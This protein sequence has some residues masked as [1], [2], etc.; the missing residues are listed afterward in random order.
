MRQLLREQRQHDQKNRAGER[1]HPDQDME[2]KADDEINWHPG[3]VEQG[4]RAETG[5]K[6]LHIVE[7]PQR[8]DSLDAVSSPQWQPHNG[9]VNALA[10][11]LV[12]R[13]ADPHQKAPADEIDDA[14]KHEQDTR[15]DRQADQRRDAA[16][17][18][19][20]V[21]D[22]QHVKRAGQH[23]NIDQAAEE[24][25]ADHRAAAGPQRRRKF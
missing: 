20:P 24:G 14:Q 5:E 4:C 17:G 21:I 22:F 8:L 25:G 16:A 11:A 18:Q 13:G 7:I 6:D 23:Q 19:H 10:D 2:C 15:Q 3:Q 12:E 1:R 9:V